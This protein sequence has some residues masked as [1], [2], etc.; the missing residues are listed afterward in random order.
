MAALA[1]LIHS[2]KSGILMQVVWPCQKGE[3]P[4]S[5]ERNR[6]LKE[7]RLIPD[8]KLQELYTILHYYR[9][10][11]QS[12][13]EKPGSVMKFAGSWS[14]LSEDEAD[15]ILQDIYQRR[16]KAFSQRRSCANGSN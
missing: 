13:Q 12:S 4:V 3:L 6:I 14:D 7:I 15:L 5:A 10:G 8:D 1:T 2:E 11:V 9:M 16:Q